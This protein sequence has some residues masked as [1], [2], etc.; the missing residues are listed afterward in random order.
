M[1][2]SY[3]TGT[4]VARKLHGHLHFAACLPFHLKSRDVSLRGSLRASDGWEIE[5]S[6]PRLL[7]PAFLSA[8]DASHDR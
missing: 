1:N 6:S 3:R 7:G 2:G 8:M 5:V 4:A